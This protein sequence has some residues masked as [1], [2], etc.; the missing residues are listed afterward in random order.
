MKSMQLDVLS[1]TINCA[2]VHMPG[3]KYPG[4]VLQG[5]S[6]RNLL[7]NVEEIS[8]LSA[9]AGNPDLSDAIKLIKEILMGYVSAYERAMKEAG[10][11]LP[12]PSPNV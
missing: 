12:Y 2:V 9:T 10:L 3:R 8:D 5:D 7:A 6:L 1:E 4:L 11:A